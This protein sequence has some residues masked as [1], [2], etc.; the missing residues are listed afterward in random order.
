MKRIH[1]ALAILAA[2]TFAITGCG[3]GGGAGGGGGGILVTLSPSSV[4]I[5]PST[6]VNLTAAVSGTTNT[7]VQWTQV[8]GNLMVLGNTGTFTA[9]SSEGTCRVTA[10]SLA[11]NTRSAIANIV[12]SN[13]APVGNV[14]VT[15][16]PDYVPLSPGGYID[17]TA[18][19]SGSSN[20]AVTWAKSGGSLSGSGNT[21]RF[22]AP[23]AEGTYT[24]TATSVAD[25]S[26]SASAQIL[27]T[28]DMPPP[29]PL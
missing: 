28:A 23:S 19:V 2:A 10:T 3:G 26:K 29:P 16:S 15:I 20:T 1:V 25:A 9:P 22:T 8:G 17:L 6:S 21:I 14:T 18:T 27:V 4:T 11:D 24:V 13:S 12:V 5:R 7:A